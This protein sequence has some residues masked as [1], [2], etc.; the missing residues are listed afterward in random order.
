[1]NCYINNGKGSGFIHHEGPLC[2]GEDMW[3]F[4]IG[5][6]NGDGKDDYVTTSKFN[7]FNSYHRL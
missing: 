1:M 2:Y 5:D 4:V 3:N 6:F 7:L